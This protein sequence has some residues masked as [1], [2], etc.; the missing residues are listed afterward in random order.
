MVKRAETQKKKKKKKHNT[1]KINRSIS[2][3]NTQVKGR[4]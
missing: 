1:V 2:E 4:G 3:E